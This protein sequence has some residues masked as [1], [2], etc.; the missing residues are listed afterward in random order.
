MLEVRLDLAA[1]YVRFHTEAETVNKA[2]D[3]LEKELMNSSP[4]IRD[5]VLEQMEEKWSQLVPLY[6]QAKNT[7]LNFISQ[8]SK[9]RFRVH[10]LYLK[11]L[12][13]GFQI[14]NLL[15]V[16]INYRLD[17]C[18]SVYQSQKTWSLCLIN[19]QWLQIFPLILQPLCLTIN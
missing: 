5:N 17:R 18:I 7:G 13:N 11:K 19:I 2:M 16:N 6:Q 14:R 15:N 1:V 3:E 8:S 12:S 4:D 10:E 9:V